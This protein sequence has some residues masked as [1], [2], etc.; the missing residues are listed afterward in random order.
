MLQSYLSQV[1][2]D[3]MTLTFNHL[4]DFAFFE[5]GVYPWS[6]VSW[7]GECILKGRGY[8]KG[9]KDWYDS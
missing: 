9:R 6:G 5:G 1:F 8:G 3:W 2:M 7:Q 4:S